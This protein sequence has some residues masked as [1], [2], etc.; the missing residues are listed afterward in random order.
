MKNGVTTTLDHLVEAALTGQPYNQRRLGD[1]AYR[2]AMSLVRRKAFELPSDVQEEVAQEAFIVLM[3]AGADGLARHGGGRSL[4]RVCLLA[5]IRRVR[6]AY[7]LPGCRTRLPVAVKAATM[8]ERDAEVAKASTAARE[9]AVASDAL[10]DPQAEDALRQVES[11]IDTEKILAQAPDGVARALRRIHWDE[12]P[13][14]IVA[15]GLSISRFAL[16]RHIGAF[17][18]LWRAAA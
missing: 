9:A 14:S 13:A 15:A 2:Y 3:E 7:V 18:D 5:A 8:S 10:A 16:R 6:A 11:R 17:S 4:F 12:E 1:E